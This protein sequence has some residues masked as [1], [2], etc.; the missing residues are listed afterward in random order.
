MT[1][2]KVQVK[3]NPAT[4][5][6]EFAATTSAP[7]TFDAAPT[8]G[9]TLVVGVYTT[10]ATANINT[11]TGWTLLGSYAGTHNIGKVAA[12]GKIAGVG[13]SANVTITFTGSTAGVLVGEEWSGLASVLTPDGSGTNERSTTGTSLTVST[14]SAT[15]AP[16]GLAFYVGLNGGS[17]GTN[18]SWGSSGFTADYEALEGVV[19]SKVLA[20]PAVVTAT[21][22]WSATTYASGL[23]VALAGP[24]GV[25]VWNGSAWVRKPLKVWNGS[26]WVQKPV[27]VWT[28]SAWVQK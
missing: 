25:K 28:G 2:T 22:S 27:K 7:F 5:N 18:Y 3:S 1:I 20:S 6:S 4:A 8:A 16:T 26:A 23:V 15:T 21:A 14:T 17:D 9:N 12:F 11:P 13:E 10:S 19:A 24:Y